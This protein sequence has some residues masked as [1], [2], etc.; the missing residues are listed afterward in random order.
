MNHISLKGF[1]S[2]HDIAKELDIVIR[3]DGL[4]VKKVRGITRRQGK[5]SIVMMVYEATMPDDKATLSVMLTGEEDTVIVD[6]V[7]TGKPHNKSIFELIKNT[8]E[9]FNFKQ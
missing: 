3:D 4:K 6:A 8:L 7:V 9:S 2:V 5:V 1:G